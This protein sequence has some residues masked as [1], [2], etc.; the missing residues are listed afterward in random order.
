MSDPD[1][2]PVITPADVMH[3]AGLACLT[4]AD[5]ELERFTHQLADILIHAQDMAALD[6]SG[7]EPM[8]HPYPL[9]NV[10]REDVVTAL[11]DRDE[12]LAAAPAVESHMFKVPPVLGEAP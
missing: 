11:V 9:R 2:R 10:L 7:V 6:T 4:I 3:V 1:D 5:D 12:V 8:S